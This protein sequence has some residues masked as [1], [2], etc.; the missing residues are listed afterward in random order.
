M[1]VL[2][3]WWHGNWNSL[4]F[5]QKHTYFPL[6]SGCISDIVLYV[7]TLNLQLWDKYCCCHFPDEAT[8]STDYK[9]HPN[10]HPPRWQRQK[11]HLC[12]LAADKPLH[13]DPT[14][15][16]VVSFTLHVL[17]ICIFFFNWCPLPYL[18]GFIFI[19]NCD[20]AIL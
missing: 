15:R 10:S 5:I 9:N 16:K 8:L 12:F 11:L 18:S 19:N 13:Q 20:V 2:C 4:F 6:A 14:W 3:Y 1:W 7:T 17:N